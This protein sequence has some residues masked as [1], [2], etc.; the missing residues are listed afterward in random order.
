[1]NTTEKIQWLKDYY[2]SKNY[3]VLEINLIGVRNPKDIEKDVIND[4]IGYFTDT[5]IFL[6]P[7]T[8]EPSVYWTTDKAERN[9]A[10]TF[11]LLPGWHEAIWCF[12]THKGYEALVNDYRYCRPTKGWRDVNYNFSQD[13]KDVIVCDY[14]GINFHRMHPVS[15]VDKIGKYSAGCQVFRSAA[16][17][18]K[19]LNKLKSTQMYKSTS[20]KT[21]FDYVLL[22]IEE[23]PEGLI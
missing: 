3:P 13:P 16:D 21:T 9:K 10:G 14:F 18:A 17:F 15:I 1:M 5:E 19:V 12:G 23:L 22:K 11:H 2:K 6:V 7:G 20:D 4:F 8:T